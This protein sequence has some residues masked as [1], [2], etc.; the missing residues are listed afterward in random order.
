M[1]ACFCFKLSA[2]AITARRS[3]LHT[4]LGRLVVAPSLDDADGGGDQQRQQQQQNKGDAAA[5]A[6]AADATAAARARAEE[7]AVL[8][9]A[10]VDKMTFELCGTAAEL[11]Q[12]W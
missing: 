4:T 2:V 10:A 1:C 12:L 5:G 6:A 9:Q 7:A 8:L 11:D 3:I